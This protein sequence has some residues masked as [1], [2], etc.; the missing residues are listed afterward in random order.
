MAITK[1]SKSRAWPKLYTGAR[2]G[3]NHPW[4]R[5]AHPLDLDRL[6]IMNMFGGFTQDFFDAYHE[7]IPKAEPHYSER[8]RLYELY[9]QYVANQQALT[10]SQHDA[11]ELTFFF[12]LNFAPGSVSIVS[13]TIALGGEHVKHRPE[14]QRS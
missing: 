11:A 8:L 12:R 10:E 14:T 4:E 3:A 6:G 5:T 13:L 9:H 2:K 1:L 7:V